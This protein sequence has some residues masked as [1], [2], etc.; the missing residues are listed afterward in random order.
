MNPIVLIM[1]IFALIGFIDK[2]FD[3]QLGLSYSF[4]DGF[5]TMLTMMYAIVGIGSVGITLIEAHLDA[6][7]SV[8]AFLPFDPSLLIGIL[9]A[10]DL[11]GY[12]ICEKISAHTTLIS[13]NGVI[14]SSLLGQFLSFQLPIF[15]SALKPNEFQIAMKGFII[16]IAAIPIGFLAGGLL[17]QTPYRIFIGELIPLILICGLA[18]LGLFR[19]TDQTLRIFGFLAKIVQLMMYLLFFFA[20][21][22]AFFP[23]FACT[24]QALIEDCVLTVL[25]SSIV[26]CGSLVLSKI[27]MKVCRKP[28]LSIANLLGVNETSVICLLLSCAT[29][30]A[31]LP[32]FSKMDTKGKMLN[33]AFA[34][35]GSY[36]IGGQ[37]GYISNMSDSHSTSVFLI[38]KIICGLFS[39]LLMLK[40]Y[41]HMSRD[42]AKNN[43]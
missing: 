6:I 18:A 2:I 28:I 1:L 11:G 5:S 40:L 8:S 9:L 22:S 12:P 26:I 4:D 16:G 42:K 35:S 21:L 29:S 24:D 13:L 19:F 30:L 27:I 37:L 39:I 10:P 33:A 25:K 32:L 7:S 34:V 14:L 41:P 17:L 3:L 20:M 23:S 15:S 38:S 36:V 31:F 43:I